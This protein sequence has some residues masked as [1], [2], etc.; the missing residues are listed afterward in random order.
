MIFFYN[1]QLSLIIFYYLV[2][3]VF[4]LLR[5]FSPGAQS[6]SV[7]LDTRVNDMKIIMCHSKP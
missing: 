1:I 5:S 2:Q 6:D 7:V 3:Y 4:E